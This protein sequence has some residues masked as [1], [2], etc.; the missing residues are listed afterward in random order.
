M[1]HLG[2]MFRAGARFVDEKF[3]HHAG[4]PLVHYSLRPGIKPD[5]D[6]LYHESS[7]KRW[8]AKPTFLI[9]FYE[10]PLST[11]T[12]QFGIDTPDEMLVELGFN[13]TVRAVGKIP[14]P[15]DLFLDCNHDKW[16]VIQRGRNDDMLRGQNRLVLTVCRF[17]ESVTTGG[18]DATA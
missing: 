17:Q 1:F 14:T 2:D 3:V 7:E 8:D 4:R 13:S 10:I 5:A 11:S 6:G 16:I 18:K 12:G 9:G 15:G